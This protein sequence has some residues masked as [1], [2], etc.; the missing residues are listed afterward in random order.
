[1]Q[2]IL[3]AEKS[4]KPPKTQVKGNL[5]SSTYEAAEILHCYNF[6]EKQEI[7]SIC[8]FILYRKYY[9]SFSENVLVGIF[10]MHWEYECLME[11]STDNESWWSDILY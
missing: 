7:K 3:N 2:N 6:V 9:Y 10:E 4:S 8:N 11:L 5:C 1:M